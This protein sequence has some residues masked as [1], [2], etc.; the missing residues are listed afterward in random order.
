VQVA[1]C[2]VFNR[3]VRYYGSLSAHFRYQ[4]GMP[5]HILTIIKLW[6]KNH[7][8]SGSWIDEFFSVSRSL[9]D[10]KSLCGRS[11]NLEFTIHSLT[12]SDAMRRNWSREPITT[13]S[14]RIS[15]PDGLSYCGMI[16]RPEAFPGNYRAKIKI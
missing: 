1:R 11:R 4:D 8:L 6:W 12:E 5:Y 7:S 2:P 16:I 9:N 13:P 10:E 14:G 3:T 15:T